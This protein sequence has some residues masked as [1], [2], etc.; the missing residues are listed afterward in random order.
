[1]S[2]MTQKTNQF[3]LTTIRYSETEIE[4]LIKSK[5]SDVYTFLVDDKFGSSG[6]TGLCILSNK[7]DQKIE[8]NSFLMSCRIIGRNIEYVFIDYIIKQLKIDGITSLTSKFIPTIKNKQ[9]LNFFEKCS[10]ELINQ[11]N[12][13]KNYFL[14][15]NKYKISKIDYVKIVDNE[16]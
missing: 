11:N 9:V 10:F 7:N 14:S 8:I 4:N 13:C 6:V 12:S 15:L 2:Q 1:M 3:N 5:N 16:N